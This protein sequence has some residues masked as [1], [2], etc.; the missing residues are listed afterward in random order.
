MKPIIVHSFIAILCSFSILTFTQKMWFGKQSINVFTYVV[1]INENTTKRLKV[2]VD[3]QELGSYSK[4]FLLNYRAYVLA[5][6]F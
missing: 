6:Y 1:D 5:T 3:S 4:T 2:I